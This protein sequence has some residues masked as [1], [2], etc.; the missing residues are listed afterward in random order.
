MKDNEYWVKCWKYGVMAFLA[1]VTVISVSCQTEAY[2]K[3]VLLQAA[4]D[5]KVPLMEVSCALYTGSSSKPILCA[6]E[7]LQ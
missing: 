5:A 3:R 7:G 2:Q 1:F 4:M 6:I